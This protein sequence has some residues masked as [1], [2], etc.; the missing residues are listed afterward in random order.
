MSECLRQHG[1]M[2]E[3]RPLIAVVLALLIGFSGAL[4]AVQAKVPATVTQMSGMACPMHS[5]TNSPA[6]TVCFCIFCALPGPG[7][8]PG[9]GTFISP[10]SLSFGAAHNFATGVSATHGPELTANLAT[11]P[12]AA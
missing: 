11:G 12:P 6:K 3:V 7:A 1:V 9:A 10:L 2:K 5:G 4:P 8:A